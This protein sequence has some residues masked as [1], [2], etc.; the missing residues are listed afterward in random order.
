MKYLVKNPKTG[1]VT[2]HTIQNANDLVQ[3]LKHVIVGKQA[4]GAKAEK[5]EAVEP[6]P[7]SD[8]EEM[9]ELLDKTSIKNGVVIPTEAEG[10]E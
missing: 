8:A 9:Q 10:D 4:D 7:K 5:V 6:A 3:H 1:E 2:P